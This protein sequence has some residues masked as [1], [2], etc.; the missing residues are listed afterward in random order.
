MHAFGSGRIH[1][2]EAQ[3]IKPDKQARV[4][5]VRYKDEHT[6]GELDFDIGLEQSCFHIKGP[7]IDE[8]FEDCVKFYS[9]NCRYLKVSDLPETGKRRTSNRA[10]CG[11]SPTVSI[12]SKTWSR[13]SHYQTS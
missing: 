5:L 11:A 9:D 8:Y 10:I 12:L 1:W 3:D 7:R 4:F 2:C 13:V 6:E